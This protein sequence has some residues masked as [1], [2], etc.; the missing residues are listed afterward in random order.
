MN[1]SKILSNIMDKSRQMSLYY[2]DKLKETDLQK[3]FVVDG[4]TLNSTFWIMAH[5]AVTE[6]WLLLRSTGAE[7]V[8]IPWARQ[9]GQGSNAVVKGET[10]P[11]DEVRAI[12]T[13]VHTKALQHVD[14]LS[15]ELLDSKN[16]TGFNLFGM[17]SI[18]DVIIH[19]IRHENSHAGHLGWICKLHGIK[20]I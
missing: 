15:D 12:F 10:P 6:N 7:H 4:K 5:L 20:T 17:H 11:L 9:Y 13:E 8:K 1:E 16:T 3:S 18:R 2:L 19:A 14:S